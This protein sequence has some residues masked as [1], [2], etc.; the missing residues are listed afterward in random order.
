MRGVTFRCCRKKNKPKKQAE[1][2]VPLLER[3]PKQVHFTGFF[4]LTVLR[5]AW[6]LHLSSRRTRCLWKAAR[7]V[8]AEQTPAARECFL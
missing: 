4:S 3:T 6:R 1:C 8:T 2:S 7:L 5:V